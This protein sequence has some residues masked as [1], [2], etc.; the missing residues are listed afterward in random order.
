MATYTVGLYNLNPS[1]LIPTGT[2]STFTW[3]G[4]SA[5]NGTAQITD[6]EAGIGGQTLD[7]DSN[8][9]EQAIATVT[10][11]GNTSLAS[12]ADAELVWTITDNVTGQT[13]EVV[14][15]QVEQGPAAGFYTLSE[16]PLVAGRS[17]TVN[18]YNSNPDATA[19]DIAFSYADYGDD[20]INGTA[21]ADLIDASYTDA[22]GLSV[23]GFTNDN[24]NDSIAAGGGNDTIAGG[25]GADTIL[26]EGGS[27]LIYGDYG[28]T[29]AATVGGTLTWTAQGGNNTDLS[30]GFT[31]D[32][33][34][35]DISVGF[36][37][38]GNNNP[39]FLV[40]TLT[41][42]VGSGENTSTVSA[43][44]LFGDGDGA[45]STTTIDFAASAGAAVEDEVQNVSFR[46]NDI[47]WG[48]GNH[49]D[50]VTVNAFD[51]LGNPVTV[52]L[53][54]GGGDTV[55]GNTI[56]A[57]TVAES[58]ADLG[59]SVLVEIAG[60][61]AQIEIIYANGQ[62]GTQAVYVTDISYEAIPL[63]GNDSIDAGNGN[64]TVFGEAGD[65][66]IIG[67]NGADSIDGG[68]GNDSLR[69][70]G[71]NDT[72]IG[73]AGND[74][75]DGG[76]NNDSIDGGTGADSVLGGAGNDTISAGQGD[77]LFGGDGNDVFTLV[78]LLEPGAGT[79]TIDGGTGA[80][81]QGDRLDLN[82][83][84][85]RTTLNITSN[86]GGEQT[87]TITMLDGT[88]VSFSNIDA[89]VC[90]TPGTRILTA[91]GYRAVETLRPGDPIVTR[92]DGIQPLRWTA[93]R[94]VLA[95]DDFAPVE[96]AQASLPGA[97]A[98]LL[99]SPQHRMLFEGYRTQL[100]FGE[101]EVF[102]AA[103]H[104]EDG[105]LVR[106]KPGGLVT[107]IHLLL[108]RH[109]VI[110]AE[111]VP[112]ESF[113]VGTQGLAALSDAAREDLF[114]TLPGLRS[115]PARYGD[116]A[117][118]CLKAHEARSLIAPFAGSGLAA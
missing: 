70:D 86:V 116:T 76:N 30:A 42:Y 84:A 109:Q 68:S 91:A 108:D 102:A 35:I 92:D 32:T 69:G 118:R 28:T 97:Q 99:V 62:S 31:Q 47:D 63:G 39:T 2:G 27:D 87:G 38:D 96:F 85:D 19:G 95:R 17:Y 58:Q 52:T 74:T 43:L 18:A 111:G 12:T 44:R 107:Y 65:D 20:V 24:Q 72:I 22:G 23:D 113:H 14:Q 8:G 88:V 61:V 51:A 101:D 115:D 15:F 53:T 21:G 1:G 104:L 112:T 77:S 37:D 80:Q 94:T 45:S 55:S 90:F 64:D 105:V 49:T 26:G 93:Q 25:A 67:G 57:E 36:T 29:T 6:N 33:G 59:G 83:L 54:P 98:P 78:D 46:I 110:C 66:T 41:E 71:G 89:I 4:S 13:F 106:R 114:A 73:G 3:T 16:Q 103:R 34:A 81:G 40:S 82:G 79:I 7:D 75:I 5:F 10:I 117:R 100:L 50:I 56:T 9:A 60:P 48:S 11:G